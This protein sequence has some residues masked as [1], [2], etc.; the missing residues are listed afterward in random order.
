[1]TEKR[2]WTNTPIAF[3]GLA[4]GLFLTVP[5]HAQQEM[6]PDHFDGP[7]A[8]PALQAH[9]AESKAHAQRGGRF[10]LPYAVN[11]DG[12]VLASGTYSLS[13]EKAPA[14]QKVA[15]RVNRGVI[16]VRPKAISQGAA[17]QNALLVR[18]DGKVARLQAIY[19]EGSVLSFESTQAGRPPRSER[20]PIS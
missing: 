15:L 2:N 19:W 14:D 16:R 8:T 9:K 4:L 5:A 1:M 13:V 12:V 17:G 20:I 10:T 3:A 11:C 6:D 7:E 18:R